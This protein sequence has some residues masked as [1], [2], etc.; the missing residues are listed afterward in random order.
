[1]IKLKS[2]VYKA[3]NLLDAEDIHLCV[4]SKVFSNRLCP[5]PKDFKCSIV[6]W[7]NI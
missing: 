7:S 3:W 4:Y 6:L 2:E 1:V 5:Y